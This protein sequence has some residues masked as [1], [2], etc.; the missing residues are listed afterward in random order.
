[1]TSVHLLD[2]CIEKLKLYFSSANMWS[3]NYLEDNC[4]FRNKSVAASVRRFSAIGKILLNIEA[5]WAKSDKN[6]C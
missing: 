3:E 2:T 6:S 4:Y 1:M 5:D